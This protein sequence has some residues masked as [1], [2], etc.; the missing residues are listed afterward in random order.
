MQPPAGLR[1]FDSNS[2]E[3]ADGFAYQVHMK[4]PS[5]RNSRLA[6]AGVLVAVILVGGTGF[7]LGRGTVDRTPEEIAPTTVATAP[8]NAVPQ[9][10]ASRGVLGRSEFIAL[11]AAAADAAASGREPGAEIT[12]AEGRRFALRLPLGCSGPVDETSNATMRWRYDAT[13][14]ALR[15]YVE[16]VR[17]QPEDWWV[18]DAPSGIDAI[19]GFWVKQPWTLSEACPPSDDQPAAGGSEP[20]LLP[21]QTLAVGQIF[22]TQDTRGTG[23]DGKAYEAV[24]RVP[25]DEL[26]TS[27]GFRIRISGRIGGGVHG[28]VRC[29]QPGGPEQRPI[30][31]VLAV[32]D[33]VAIENAASND[34]LATWSV[35]QQQPA[36][37]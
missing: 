35:D 2:L 24:V 31:L 36:E 9:Y 4:E 12:D 8:S 33:E 17:W 28:P 13:D 16:P 34:T 5:P 19:E 27:R 7:L 29:H 25:E 22:A 3:R 30:C 10:P 32:L 18:K 26:D 14:K 23:R 1:T 6:L 21:G 11:A 37:N 15:L 20:V